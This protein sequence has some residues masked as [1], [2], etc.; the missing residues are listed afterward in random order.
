MWGGIKPPS[1]SG[2]KQIGE[3][4][5]YC[6]S[7]AGLTA[8]E[9][10]LR[11]PADDSRCFRGGTASPQLLLG[12][13]SSRPEMYGSGHNTHGGGRCPCCGGGSIFIRPQE[14]MLASRAEK[15]QQENKVEL[16]S[17]HSHLLSVS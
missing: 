14:S 4:M 1:F 2:K 6:C 3:E 12:Q 10:G 16:V 8:E 9:T 13:F 7:E 15:Y 5:S 17:V 11:S